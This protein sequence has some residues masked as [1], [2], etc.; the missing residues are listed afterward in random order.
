MTIVAVAALVAAL[1][2]VL[3][4]FSFVRWSLRTIARK[5]AKIDELRQD[6]ME[7]YARLV[8]QQLEMTPRERR[9]DLEQEA[10][11]TRREIDSARIIEDPE[12]AMEYPS[13]SEARYLE[14]M[15]YEQMLERS[16]GLPAEVA[17]RWAEDV[18]ADA[19][20][21][22]LVDIEVDAVR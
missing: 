10:H 19:A 9:A 15:A 7:R 4:A 5:D 2:I 16:G 3:A 11:R 18:L 1:V 20:E 22:L 6:S 12:Q 14:R 21:P 13:P 17:S 8:G